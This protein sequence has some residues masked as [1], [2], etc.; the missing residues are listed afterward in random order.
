MIEP[1][2]RDTSPRMKFVNVLYRFLMFCLILATFLMA[3]LAANEVYKASQKITN[4]SEGIIT[5][6]DC[7]GH[8]PIAGRQQ[9]DVDECLEKL[10]KTAR[11]EQAGVLGD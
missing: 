9:S 5:Y 4:Q 6:L 11:G 3:G 8:L 1:L 7:V 10:K 2:P